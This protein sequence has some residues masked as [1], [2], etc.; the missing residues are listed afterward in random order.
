MRNLLE[1]PV[2]KEEARD[3]LLRMQKQAAEDDEMAMG[4]GNLDAFILTGAAYAIMALSDE[5]FRDAFAI[6]DDSEENGPKPGEN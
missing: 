2:T 5:A 1:Y 6:A 3:C 4:C